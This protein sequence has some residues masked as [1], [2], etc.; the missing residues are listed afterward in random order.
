MLS[1]INCHSIFSQKFYTEWVKIGVNL[2]G[3]FGVW[4]W[5]NDCKLI[6]I[7]NLIR[8]LNNKYDNLDARNYSQTSIIKIKTRCKVPITK[9]FCIFL[10]KNTLDEF[11]QY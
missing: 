4:G 1:K 6:Y 3:V 11:G 8:W 7:T 10:Q 9:K 5:G 2:L